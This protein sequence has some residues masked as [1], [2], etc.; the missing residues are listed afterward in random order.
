MRNIEIKN[1]VYK[2]HQVY[3]LYAANESGE[4]INI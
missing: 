1:C 3:D 2:V 4:I